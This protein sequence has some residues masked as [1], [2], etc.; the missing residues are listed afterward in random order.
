M[1]NTTRLRIVDW[2]KI[3]PIETATCTVDWYKI[4]TLWDFG[5]DTMD[6]ARALLSDRTVQV[7]FLFLSLAIC[8]CVKI[9][10]AASVSG[11]NQTKSKS[12]SN[13]GGFILPILFSTAIIGITWFYIIR[14][15]LTHLNTSESYFD[16]AYKDVLRDGHY[17]TSS[18]LL[19][20]AI[21]AV[22]WAVDSGCDIAFF[23]FGFLGAMG[24]SFVLWA[25]TLYRQPS[26]GRRGYQRRR[27]VPLTFVISSAVAFASILKL[28]PCDPSTNK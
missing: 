15:I 14:F 12:M 23:L 22:V 11:R 26:A 24:A 19:T 6:E 27:M 18:Q 25:P 17:F 20:W 9:Y 7:Y 16:D 1:A 8:R 2:Y 28:R 4:H 10:I 3:N 21:V 13:S 5:V